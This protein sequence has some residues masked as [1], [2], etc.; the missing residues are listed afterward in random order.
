MLPKS[1]QSAEVAQTIRTQ[2]NTRELDAVQVVV[3]DTA[4]RTA[5][6]PG[7]AQRLSALPNVSR[8]DALVGSYARGQKVAEPTAASRQFTAQNATY[9]TVVP[10]VD[11]YSEKGKKLVDDIRATSAPFGVIVGGTPAVNADTFS[12]L[13]DRLPIA[14]AIL[15]IGMFLLLYLLSGSVVLPLVAIVLSA[16]SLSATFGAVVFIFQDGHLQW[17]VGDFITT[18]ALIWLIPITIFGIAF[19]LSMDYQVFMLSRIK[20]EYDRT[21]DHAK[22]V[23]VGLER[24]GRVI[25]YAALLLSTVFVVWVSSGLNYMKAFGVGIPLAI[26]MDA[27]VI[28]GLLLPAIMK[29]LGRA[30]WWAPAPLRALHARLGLREAPEP[31]AAPDPAGPNPIKVAP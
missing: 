30:S 5:D 22:A 19:G 6:L 7:Y 12:T 21:G 28:R 29:L 27:T 10:T 18:G 20:E 25:T 26:L 8:V 14:G 4:G 13:Y 31:A 1:A 24:T 11:G 15:V 17:L 9:L 3:P 23:A 2:F 16:L